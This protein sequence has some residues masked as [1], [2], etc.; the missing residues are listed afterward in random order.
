MN[1]ET[2]KQDVTKNGNRLG[3]RNLMDPD[4]LITKIIP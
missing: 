3:K 1:R 4:K 2:E